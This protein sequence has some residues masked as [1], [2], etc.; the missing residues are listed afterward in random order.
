MTIRFFLKSRILS[1]SMIKHISFE[2]RN[3]SNFNSRLNHEFFEI[4]ILN[5]HLLF[6]NVR[7]SFLRNASINLSIDFLLLE[8]SYNH[9]CNISLTRNSFS[10]FSKNITEKRTKSIFISI[11]KPLFNRRFIHQSYSK[12]KK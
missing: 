11:L 1:N 9:A 3:I 12:I 6:Y 10:R 7:I 2:S 8:F 4:R 5:R